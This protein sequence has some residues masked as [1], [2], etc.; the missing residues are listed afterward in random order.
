MKTNRHVEY[1]F[2]ASGY[3]NST[4]VLTDD[5]I[6]PDKL[7]VLLNTGDAT[8]SVVEG[9]D[10]ILWADIAKPKV[11]GVV[12]STEPEMDYEEFDIIQVT[13]F[14]HN[15]NYANTYRGWWT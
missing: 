14:P 9:Q 12:N 3:V 7:M 10:V 5:S 6:T 8:T 2:L 11:I 15:R 1:S 13:D 4:I